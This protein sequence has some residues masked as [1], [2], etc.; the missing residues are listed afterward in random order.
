MG[1][2]D[3]PDA[4]PDSGVDNVDVMDFLGLKKAESLKKEK[5]DISP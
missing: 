4:R 2:L 5:D 3:V 1:Q